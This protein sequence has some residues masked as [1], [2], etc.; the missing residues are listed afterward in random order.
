VTR[1]NQLIAVEI[2]HSSRIEKYRRRIV[3][4]NRGTCVSVTLPGCVDL[5]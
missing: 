1:D 4:T 3:S 2:H 5:D